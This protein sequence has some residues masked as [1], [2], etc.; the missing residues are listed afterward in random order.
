MPVRPPDD[1]QPK[2]ALAV[3]GSDANEGLYGMEVLEDDEEDLEL[4]DIE[5]T[6]VAAQ[7]SEA[8]VAKAKP[9][10]TRPNSDEVA[11]RHATHCPFRS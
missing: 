5:E 4:P 7:S 1:S 10:P 8:H 3:G 2:A 9:A 11:A 6:P